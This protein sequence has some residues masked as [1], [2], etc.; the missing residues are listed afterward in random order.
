MAI[1]VRSYQDADCAA[2]G[3]LIAATYS[4]Y[5]LGFAPEDQQAKLLGPFQH[6]RS[7][8]PAH[9]AEIARA[10]LAPTVLVAVAGDE[11]VGVLRGRPGRLHSLFVREDYHRQGVGRLLMRR[12][13]AESAAHGVTQ[14]T[15]ASSLYAVPFYRAIGYTRSTG[16]RS[17]KSFGTPGLLVQPMKKLLQAG[18]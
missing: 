3:N 18:E 7:E 17:M 9:Q 11:V 14:I 4:R 2:V 5:N 15:L 6:A 12:F 16:L 10:I 1:Q 8:Q 13:E